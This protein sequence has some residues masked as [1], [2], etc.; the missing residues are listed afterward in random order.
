M[1]GCEADAFGGAGDEHGLA[2]EFEFHDEVMSWD[3]F[4][5]CGKK[6]GR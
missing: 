2:F 5:R 4:C 1:G 6:W 3:A